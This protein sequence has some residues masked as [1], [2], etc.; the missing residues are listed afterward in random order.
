LGV[1][2]GGGIADF[3]YQLILQSTFI[4]NKF[5]LKNN[6]TFVMKYLVIGSKP[7]Y[8]LLP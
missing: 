7:I 2:V 5:E 4:T 1:A 6:S 3:T 8:A